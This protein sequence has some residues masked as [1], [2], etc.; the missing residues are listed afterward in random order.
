VCVCGSN[1]LVCH[2]S[3][4]RFTHSLTCLFA[5]CLVAVVA[6]GRIPTEL[7]QLTALTQLNL[8][9]NKLTGERVCVCVW[10]KLACLP[11]VNYLIDHSLTYPLTHSLTHSHLFVCLL[12]GCCCLTGR[13]PTELGQLT[14]VTQLYLSSNQLTG[15]CVCV[16]DYNSLDCDWSTIR[17]TTHSLTLACLFAFL[18]VWL[19]LFRQAASQPSLGS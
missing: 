3:T 8:F 5:C 18:C 16:C 11:L 14:V 13:I 15:E 19:L 1:S 17:S 4:I 2:W 10:L 9:N 7:G 12:S 6:T